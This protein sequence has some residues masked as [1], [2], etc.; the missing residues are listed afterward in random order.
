MA[1]GR[2][3]EE[4][5]MTTEEINRFSKAM[6]DKKFSELLHEYAQE[7]SNPENKKKYE[8]EITQLEQERGMEVKFIHPNAHH[9]LKTSVNGKEK[10]FINICSNN[11][12][13]KPTCEA[14]RN[15]TGRAGQYWS[16]PYSLTPGRPHTDGKGN[17]CMI[18]DVVFHPDTL[19]MA[20][21]N[22]R[23]MKL[24]NDTATQGVEDAFNVTT[25]KTNTLLKKTRYK[26]VPQAAVI[27]KPIPGQPKNEESAAHN[28]AFPILYPDTM[29]TKDFKSLSSSQTQTT[30]KQSSS[31]PTQPHHTIKYRSLVDLQDYRC[32]KDSAPKTRPK[33][34]VISIY[35]PLL[36]SAVDVDLNVMDRKLTLESQKPD[37]KLELHLS[38]PVDDNKGVAQ[39]N[40]T[41]KQ[42]TVTL[43]V[44]PAENPAEVHVESIKPEP[45]DRDVLKSSDKA[46]EEM[47]KDEAS[48][49]N[50]SDTSC[51][52]QPQKKG[53]DDDKLFS[54]DEIQN[55][56]MDS[57]E[58]KL[59]GSH[60]AK[61]DETLTY[62]INTETHRTSENVMNVP[63][64][65]FLLNA[66]TQKT[67]LEFHAN[68]EA[69]NNQDKE[70]LLSGTKSNQPSYMESSET[71]EN[72]TLE[73]PVVE[74]Q[75]KQAASQLEETLHD[76]QNTPADPSSWVTGRS[77]VQPSAISDGPNQ[78]NSP[79]DKDT[80]KTS[81]RAEEMLASSEQKSSSKLIST[82]V[83]QNEKVDDV[84][85]SRQNEA[86]FSISTSPD[87]LR[88]KNPEDGSEVIISDHT[89]SAAL[90]FQNSLW[91]ELE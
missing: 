48:E 13:S 14:R 51:E 56:K 16:L 54:S 84:D 82:R 45:E 23:F 41:T 15:E 17:K 53:K 91:F 88:E 76:V 75:M 68:K 65:G 58:S 44:Q 12:I 27:R 6:K 83:A 50:I 2:K 32:S 72:C 30:T 52:A 28:E 25:D 67:S 85:S 57:L 21:K 55:C 79:L 77:E 33:E 19:Y 63:K 46:N 1:F 70:N 29:P 71:C 60:L 73:I 9:V 49:L 78:L 36:K 66:C 47:L 90:C 87:I 7:I 20:S 59:N 35:L 26:G 40:T 80:R 43:P 86:D 62:Q 11:L 89:T 18:Y 42:L 4:L 64:K 61:A 74:L 37:Y 8:E 22:A 81:C 38:Y 39:F 10:C 34:I 69:E 5:N 3:L 24:V 31:L